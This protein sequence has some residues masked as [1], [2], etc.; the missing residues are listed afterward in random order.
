MTQKFHFG[1]YI[2][3][4]LQIFRILFTIKKIIVTFSLS[5]KN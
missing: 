4:V 1:N 3:F 5:F 2:E